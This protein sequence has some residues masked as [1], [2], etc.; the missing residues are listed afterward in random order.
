MNRLNIRTVN[1]ARHNGLLEPRYIKIQNRAA[2]VLDALDEDDESL[3]LIAH[4]HRLSIEQIKKD[5]YGE[6]SE[7][8]K[9]F[10]I[11]SSNKLER[12]LKTCLKEIKKG[13]HNAL[14]AVAY[15]VPYTLLC[16]VE[17]NNNNIKEAAT[18]FLLD[19]RKKPN[20]LNLTKVEETNDVNESLAVSFDKESCSI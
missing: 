1:G 12:T 6:P 9:R 18:K 13:V 3:E 2:A 8:K 11:R 14:V 15:H 4:L 5:L 19:I 17:N 10:G 7:I 20:C 16:S